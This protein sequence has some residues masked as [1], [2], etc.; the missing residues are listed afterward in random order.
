VPVIVTRNESLRVSEE[1]LVVHSV[2]E[3]IQLAQQHGAPE[4]VVLGGGEI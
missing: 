2:E 4:L 3:G 1:G